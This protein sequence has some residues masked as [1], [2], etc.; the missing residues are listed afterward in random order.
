MLAG[1][2]AISCDSDPAPLT[3]TGENAVVDTV[4]MN[5]SEFETA[6]FTNKSLAFIT[7]SATWCGSCRKS[8]PEIE[9]AAEEFKGRVVFGRIDYDQ[10]EELVK[11]INVRGVPTLLV[12]KDGKSVATFEGPPTVDDIR[13]ILNPLLPA[14]AQSQGN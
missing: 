6:V 5:R 9:A 1:L 2:L 7:I 10:E 3:I 8:A 4:L 14:A 11:Q 12:F 13:G